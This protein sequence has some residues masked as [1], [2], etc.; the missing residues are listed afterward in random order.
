MGGP[1][2]SRHRRAGGSVLLL[3]ALVLGG[4]AGGTLGSGVGDTWLDRPP[5]YAGGPAVDGDVLYLPVHV[6]PDPDAPPRMGASAGDGPELARLV[7]AMNAEV[8]SVGASMG[9]RR[10]PSA[11]PG[12]PP[13]V[14]LGC[15]ADV[16]GDCV[17]EE[18]EIGDAVWNDELR[19]AVTRGSTEW[20]DAAV[21]MLARE[22]ASAIV[23]VT[24]ETGWHWPRQTNWR[25]SKVVELG[26]DR[27]QELPWLTAL[28]RPVQ[29]LQVTALAFGPDGRVVRIGG[30]GLLARRT[31][32]VLSGFGVDALVREEDVA[33]LLD[34]GA[35]APDWRGAV[36]TLLLQ[37]AA[38]SRS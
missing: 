30:E 2:T 15:E 23:V 18:N 25:G 37:L 22:S 12:H 8:A 21:D 36:E 33:R 13:D 3:P 31:P 38:R 9:W 35:D 14:Q 34:G 6:Q 16:T 4:C 19:L 28:D 11:I 29:V 5:F 24:I 1:V 26:S 17:I 10:S 32:I 20:R 27:E 7:E